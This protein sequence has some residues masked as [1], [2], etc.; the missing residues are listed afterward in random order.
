MRPVV[1]AEDAL[2]LHRLVRRPLVG[3]RHDGE[4]HA[5]GVAQ[6]NVLP[7]LDLGR[8]SFRDVERDRHRPERAV[9]EPHLLDT[10]S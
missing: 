5:L 4:D 2:G 6:R 9:R 8:E 1:G 3:D 7:R 10:R